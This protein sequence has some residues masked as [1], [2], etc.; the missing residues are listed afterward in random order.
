[1][2]PISRKYYWE[3]GVEQT[4]ITE[5]YF[6]QSSCVNR[7][8][9]QSILC[10][11]LRTKTLTSASLFLFLPLFA[12]HLLSGSDLF[13]MSCLSWISLATKLDI[14]CSNL[15]NLKNKIT[16]IEHNKIFCGPSK[17]LKNITWLIN[18]CL[19][20]FMTPTK[21]LQRP[22]YILNVR[23]LISNINGFILITTITFGILIEKLTR[24]KGR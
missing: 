14:L 16:K 12:L 21:T 19:K 11:W 9:S 18:I 3:N 1:M 10:Q 4:K 23:S 2:Q 5:E 13:N 17:M 8:I 22:S 6:S 20:Y 15:L 7:S 24:S